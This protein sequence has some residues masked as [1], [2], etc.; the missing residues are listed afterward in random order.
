MSP[1]KSESAGS[2]L[3]A[4][5]AKAILVPSSLTEAWSE[6]WSPAPLGPVLISVVDPDERR[7]TWP[8][9]LGTGPTFM[10]AAVSNATEFPSPLIDGELQSRS[11]G[12]FVV[13]VL[14]TRLVVGLPEMSR[15]QISEWLTAV[16]RL[17]AALTK[18]IRVPSALIDGNQ[19]VAFASTADGPF[20]MLTSCV[21]YVFRS[22]T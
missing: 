16:P 12:R 11:A 10:S 1:L 7:Y 6:L 9:L 20:E 19:A 22:R 14:L 18:A 21:T 17:V 15:T 3:W 13:F 4:A 8:M 2:R 5:L